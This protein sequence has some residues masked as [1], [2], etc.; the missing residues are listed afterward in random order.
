MLEFTHLSHKGNRAANQD[1]LLTAD[2]LFAVADGVGGEHFGDEAAEIA[3]SILND[4]YKRFGNDVSVELINGLLPR[5]LNLY[6]I[7]SE[8]HDEKRRMSTT[9]AACYI[10][11]TSII[12][13]H[14]G[15]SRIYHYRAQ[16][17]DIWHSRDHSLVQALADEGTISE[18]EMQEHPLNNRITRA[19]SL[20]IDASKR[21]IDIHE[22]PSVSIGD[23][24]IICS[25][26]VQEALTEIELYNLIKHSDSPEDIKQTIERVCSQKS[27]DNYSAVII[28]ITKDI[29]SSADSNPSRY[30]RS[31]ADLEAIY[32]PLVS[33]KKNSSRKKY[34]LLLILAIVFLTICILTILN[35]L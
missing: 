29:R 15:D 13:A 20:D 14:I 22:F 32:H 26:G 35:A 18:A 10:S 12:A 8:K 16:T 34:W 4:E 11:E 19:I 5:I 7:A 6:R 31:R 23:T 24:F 2:P 3:L 17:E 25:D 27:S 33:S 21:T 28:R 9:L 1:R 30:Y